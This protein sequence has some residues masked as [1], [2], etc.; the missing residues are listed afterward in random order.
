MANGD[1]A[2]V[3]GLPVVP[4]TADIRMGY[5]EINLT[6]DKVATHMTTGTHTQDKIIGLPAAIASKAND[7]ATTAALATKATAPATGT[8]KRAVGDVTGANAIGLR[9]N[10][11]HLVSRVDGA[12]SELP[13][14]NELLVAI[15]TIEARLDAHGI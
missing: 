2:S 15:A 6:R 3:T 12:E 9:W 13:S 4:P 5:D 11:A 1:I 10:G 7:A 8:S 14:R